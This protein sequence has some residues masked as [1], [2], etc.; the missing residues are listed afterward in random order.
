MEALKEVGALYIDRLAYKDAWCL[1]VHKGSLVLLEALVT[2]LAGRDLSTFDLS[3]LTLHLPVPRRPAGQ[4]GWYGAHGMEQRA[5]FCESYEGY[6]D[7][8]SCVYPPWSPVPRHPVE[9]AMREVIPV[10]IVTSRRLTHV[11]RQVGQ[12]WASPGGTHT[13]ITIFV[14]GHNPEALDLGTLLQV[15][16]V[17]HTDPAPQGST[18]RIS[19]HVKFVLSKVFEMYPEADKAIIL[20]DDLDLSPDFIPYFQQTAWLLTADSRLFCVNAH[21]YNA[22]AHTALD[23]TRLYRVHGAPAYGWM[24][25]RAV[26]QDMIHKWPPL[27]AGVD[28]D[29]WVRKNVMGDR[30]LLV[31]EIPRTKHRGSG[32]VHVTGIEQEQY[33]NHRPLN[34]LINVTMD[35]HGAELHRYLRF[36]VRNI[37]R[38]NIVRFIQHPCKEIPVPRHQVNQSYVVYVHRE[39]LSNNTVWSYYVV[40]RCLGFNDRNLHDHLQMMYT[41][42]FYGNQLYIIMCPFSPFCLTKEPGDVYRA[43]QEDVHYATYHP[44]RDVL[45]R[46]TLVERVTPRDL[47]DEVNLTNLVYFYKTV[48]VTLM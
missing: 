38:G 33:F 20:E 41:G 36:H 34:S 11:L 28:W 18:N 2:S 10:A 30:D 44:F 42:S 16:V 8:C 17:E 4:C 43:T 7:F 21:N 27:N 46:M 22:F 31:P 5:A 6:G 15:P 40:A 26:A 25:T 35:V 47:S 29:L 9:Y 48:T 37:Q 12:V 3:P 24:V 19:Y 23:A 45:T 1:L 14:D 13:P 39:S 32:G